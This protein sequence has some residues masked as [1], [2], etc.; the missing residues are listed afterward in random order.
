MGSNRTWL[1]TAACLAACNFQQPA[2][3][4]SGRVIDGRP[5]DSHPDHTDASLDAKSAC[6][7]IG[8]SNGQLVAPLVTTAPTIDGDLSD[9]T[10]CFLTLDQTTAGQL[11]SY[12][13]GTPHYVS[14]TYSICHDSGHV[15]FAAEVAGI[16]PLGSEGVPD[17]WEN[18]AVEVYFHGSGEGS[19]PGYDANALQ[20]VVDH[21]NREQAFANN[22]SATS[23]AVVSATATSGDAYS[24]EMSIAPATL[25]IGSFGSNMGFDLAFDNGN[26]SAQLTQLFW[27]NACSAT[28]D[29][30]D[31]S[32]CDQPFCD[33]RDFGN[34]ALAQ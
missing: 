10:T 5:I 2:Q 29:M 1:V 12:T 18:N 16:A 34:L 11:E 17:N 7:P 20:I 27:F 15:Y 23:T 13:S 32:S 22:N 3:P 19:A 31:G 14:G 30:C 9:W 26:G 8:G 6:T 25:S 24:V 28:G 33:E 21:A 4:D